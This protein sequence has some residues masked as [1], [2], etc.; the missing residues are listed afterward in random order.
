MSASLRNLYRKV[1]N[2][3]MG[4]FEFLTRVFGE[5]APLLIQE[6]WTRAQEENREATLSRAD[7]V[8]AHESCWFQSD[9][10]VCGAKVALRR[11]L[12]PQPP[13]LCQEG[14]WLRPKR[15]NRRILCVLCLLWFLP[16]A[17]MALHNR[18]KGENLDERSFADI[19]RTLEITV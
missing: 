15:A 16:S 13:L 9:H 11:L 1:R 18:L 6:G 7:G 3:L 19:V 12:V 8:V 17:M 14:S 4:Q 5:P 10:P 2:K